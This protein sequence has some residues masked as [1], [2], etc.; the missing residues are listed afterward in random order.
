M[1]LP[2]LRYVRMLLLP[3]LQEKGNQGTIKRAASIAL[4]SPIKQNRGIPVPFR[5]FY[6][7][8]HVVSRGTFLFRGGLDLWLS[9]LAADVGWSTR[10]YMTRKRAVQP[11][12]PVEQ[13]RGIPAPRTPPE[14][15]PH[16]DMRHIC[17]CTRLERKKGSRKPR[18]W[19]GLLGLVLNKIS[20]VSIRGRVARGDRGATSA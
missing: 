5:R 8:S 7:P 14:F 12:R 17:A 11:S 18:E 15:P 19:R 13:N 6:F 10:A 20:Q 16:E 2:L 4:W 9:V 1:L 3:F